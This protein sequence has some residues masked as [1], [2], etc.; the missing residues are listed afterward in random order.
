MAADTSA[1]ADLESEYLRQMQ[2]LQARVSKCLSG[3]Q[4]RA[5]RKHKQV[6]ARSCVCELTLEHTLCPPTTKPG[7]TSEAEV[8]SIHKDVA[9][10]EHLVT[11][12]GGSSSS[13][14]AGPLTTLLVAVEPNGL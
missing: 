14:W 5:H 1:F 13:K 11:I 4:L 8:A 9:E 3:K 7:E 12:S 6:R 10:P 2:V